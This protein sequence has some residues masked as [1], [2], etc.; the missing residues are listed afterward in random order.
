MFATRK[1]MAEGMLDLALL[2]ANSSQ[3]KHLLMTDGKHKFFN[4]M[5]YLLVS[6]ICLQILI[7]LALV[8]LTQI[9]ISTKIDQSIQEKARIKKAVFLNNVIVAGIF[10]LAVV[11][12]IISSFGMNDPNDS[13]VVTKK[14]N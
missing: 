8:Y 4:L 6:S 1:T 3:L 7:G 13:V 11:N 2:L 5:L 10:L 14:H 9:Q 12:V